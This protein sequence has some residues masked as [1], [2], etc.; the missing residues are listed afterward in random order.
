MSERDVG[1]VVADVT[2]DRTVAQ[3]PSQMAGAAAAEVENSER[4]AFVTLR[5]KPLHVIEH[6]VVKHVVVVEHLIVNR[7]LVEKFSGIGSRHF[8][9]AQR[10]ASFSR[11]KDSR[12]HFVKS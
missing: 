6:F 3:S 10:T 2:A 7:P 5:Q 8:F 11:S 1:E 4:A 12:S 9:A